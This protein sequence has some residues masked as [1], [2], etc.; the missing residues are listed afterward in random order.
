MA[1]ITLCFHALNVK[2]PTQEAI[3]HKDIATLSSR[4]DVLRAA[5]NH[6]LRDTQTRLPSDLEWPFTKTSLQSSEATFFHAMFGCF[7]AFGWA[8]A[9][10]CLYNALRQGMAD[11]VMAAG[12]WGACAVFASIL[13]LGPLRDWWTY[14]IISSWGFYAG[15]LIWALFMEGD[16]AAT[17]TSRK[18]Q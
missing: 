17:S 16:T 8:I 11:R 18:P 14:P 12:I 1:F 9:T 7:A 2:G 13:C 6:S 15:I 3:V 5:T 10:T 4:I